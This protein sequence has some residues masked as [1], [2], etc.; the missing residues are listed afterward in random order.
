[1]L[2]KLKKKVISALFWGSIF[3]LFTGKLVS[4]ESVHLNGY[5][6]IVP[7]RDKYIAVGADGRIDCISKS[8]ESVPIDNSSRYKLNGAY[9]ND[10]ILIA[11]G[12][13][14]TILYS[15]NGKSL[16]HAESGSVKNIN[17]ITLRNGLIIAGTE[18]G[19]IL[20]SNDGKLWGPIKTK[21]KSNVL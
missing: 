21:A 4:I 16:S 9:A 2:I 12:E 20:I 11:V 6:D 17:G 3:L 13:H 7:F 18:S 14:G 5:T 1:M 19:I 15:F 8:G 10:E